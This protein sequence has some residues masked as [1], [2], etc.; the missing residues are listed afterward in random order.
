MVSYRSKDGVV[1]E[2]ACDAIAVCSGLHA[3]PSIPV[4]DG[5]DQVQTVIHS[6]DFKAR[7]QFGIGKTVAILGTGETGLDIAYLAITSPTKRVVLC[8]RDG[9]CAVPK[10]SAQ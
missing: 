6:A 3:T 9:F 10:V 1:T 4:I 7:S 5:M 8:H 2:W